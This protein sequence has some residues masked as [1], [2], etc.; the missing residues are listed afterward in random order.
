MFSRYDLSATKNLRV[1]LRN[2]LLLAAL[3]QGGNMLAPAAFAISQQELAQVTTPQE[4]KIDQFRNAEIKQLQVVLSRS[5]AREKQPDLLLRL[6]ELYTEKYRLYFGKENDIWSKQMDAYLQLPLAQQK[7]RRRPVLDTSTSKRWLAQAVNTLEKI[8]VQKTS[9]ERIDEVYYFLGFNQWELGK[10]NAASRAFEKIV[11]SY[12]KS[13]F[14]PEAYRYLGD[15]AFAQREFRDSRKYYEQ[16]ARAGNTPARPRVLYGLG[17]SQFKLKD[18]KRAVSTMREAILAGR[19]NSEAAK[20]GLALQRDAAESLALF[21][22]EGGDADS[23]ADFF[24][25]LFGEGEALPVLRKLAQNY[26]SQGKYAKALGINKQLLSMG[27]AAAKEGEEQRFGIMVDSLNVAVTKGD[28]ARQAALLKSMTAEFVTNSKEPNPERVEILRTQVRK[29]ATFAHREANKSKHPQDA[30]DRA[31]DLYRLY[32]SAFARWVKP[33]DA[34]EIRFYLTDVLSQLNRHREA[35]TEYKAILDLAQTDPAYKKYAKDSAASLVYSLD[36]YFKSKGAGKALSK[37]D[38]DQLIAAI[39]SY[40]QAYPNDKEVPKYLARASGVLVTSGRSEE[41]RPRLLDMIARYPKSAEAWDAATTLLKEADKRNDTD[42]LESLTK[43]F[44]ANSALM[45]QDKKGTFHA[46]LE[47]IASRASFSKV[48][49]VEENKD[50]AGAAAAYEKLAESAK[51]A[52]VRRVSL[53]NAAVSYAKLGDKANELRVY[54]KILQSSPGNSAAE[55]AILGMAS[56]HFLSGRYSEAADVFEDYYQIYEPKLTSLK[57]HSQSTAVESVRSAALLRRALKQND[58]AAEDFKLIVNAANKGVGSAKEAAGEFLF[59][60]AKKFREEGNAP[61]AIRHFQKY[62]SAFPDGPHVA[63]STMETAILYGQLK[64]EEKAQSYLRTTISKVKAK[65]KRASAEELG[66][67]AHARLELLGPL[68]AAY[69]NATLNLPEKRLKA[70]INAKLAALERLNKGYIEVMEFG[71]GTWGVEAFRRMALVYKSFAQKL[72]AAP[73]PSEYSV[74]DKAK[75]RAQLKTVAAPIYQKVVETL[76]TVLQK[77]EQLQVV[78]PVMARTYVLAVTNN[79]KADRLP[80][81]QSV[82]WDNAKEWIMGDVPDDSDALETKRKALRARSE[83]YSAWVAIGNY[84]LL[85][86]QDELAEIFYLYALQKNSKYTPAINNLAYLKGKEGDMTKA[87]SGFKTA[88]NHDEFAVTPKKNM[89]RLQMAS[90]L[91]RHA[92]L[93]YRQLEVRNP[94]DREVKRGLA[95]SALASGKLSQVNSDLIDDGDDGKYAEAILALAKG[96]RDDA[97]SALKSLADKNEYAKLIL[98]IW[99]D[100]E[101]T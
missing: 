5:A 61:E 24:T 37:A 88:L 63:G 31:D 22:S 64:E 15:F 27:G 62:S 75:F 99:K 55:K 101:S 42:D 46:K 3:L 59:D 18:Y 91:W 4:A 12:P 8:P 90:G 6:A 10:K 77:G 97:A 70:D 30:F 54:K 35:A 20:A 60:L 39:D 56:E 25:D 89:A 47:S 78:G 23:A 36:A 45:S 79:A 9:Y 87:M 74:E 84:H 98:D 16:A 66:Y 40:V 86:G 57:A 21:Y 96:K 7:S 26:Q 49:K 13:R 95:L 2:V 67:A 48:Q 94:S 33:D 29:A 81:I 44:L 34:A 38:A 19:N 93:L 69:E 71:D 1:S 52:E 72:E 65:G 73:V 76:D 14:A 11:T 43:A 92:S 32:L 50:F 80:L 53:N 28:R 83:D 17:W 41:A 58:K 85:K 100:K 68:E 82:K 51:D